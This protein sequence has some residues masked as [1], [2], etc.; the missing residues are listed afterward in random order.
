M[1]CC[2]GEAPVHIPTSATRSGAVVSWKFSDIENFC[3][4]SQL[5]FIIQA[6]NNDTPLEQLV[7]VE[8]QESTIQANFIGLQRHTAFSYNG[9][10]LLQDGI[11]G[12]TS[13]LVR[14][15]TSEYIISVPF[16]WSDI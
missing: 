5:V 16:H 9:K 14:F 6:E 15:T 10:W 8:N 4:V 7:D 12:E 1:S 11:Y 3:Q 13:E 2:L